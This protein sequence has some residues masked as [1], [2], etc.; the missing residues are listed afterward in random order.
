MKLTLLLALA[1]S[2]CSA[3]AVDVPAFKFQP[4]FNFPKWENGQVP[5]SLK[6]VP[7]A[8]PPLPAAPSFS[9]TPS[10]DVRNI[11]RMPIVPAPNVDPKMVHAP[12]PGVDYKLI[13]I[14]PAVEAAK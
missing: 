7:P 9:F 14:S 5:K 12:K 11:S 2:P 6:E 8:A 13:V 1:A 3:F 4:P 10:P